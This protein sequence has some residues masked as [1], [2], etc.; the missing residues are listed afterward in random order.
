MVA[1][2]LQPPGRAAQYPPTTPL[3]AA[4][5]TPGEISFLGRGE[6]AHQRLPGA[7]AGVAAGE[8][9]E[10]RGYGVARVDGPYAGDGGD[11]AGAYAW[12]SR[13]RDCGMGDGGEEEITD[14]RRM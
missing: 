13:R 12:Q 5:R 8:A 9:G 6:L 11:W 2:D 10:R 7:D 4:R 1:G 3:G 14:R